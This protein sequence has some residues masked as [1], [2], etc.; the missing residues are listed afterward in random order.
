M[1]KVIAFLALA[2]SFIMTVCSSCNKAADP[3]K[4]MQTVLDRI[5]PPSFADKDYV[6]TDFLQRNRHP[7][8]GSDTERHQGLL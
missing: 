8:Y 1:K 7:L 5:I 6:I 2:S 4:E 3:W